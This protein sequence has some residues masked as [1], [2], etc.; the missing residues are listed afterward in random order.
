[1]MMTITHKLA[2]AAA[3]DAAER[4]MRERSLSQ[5]DADCY[6]RA[7]ETFNRLWPAPQEARQT[8]EQ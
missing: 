2:M 3:W 7:C 8:Q 6:N 5:W 1:M 4:L